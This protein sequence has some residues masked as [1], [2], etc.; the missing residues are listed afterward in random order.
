MGLAHGVGTWFLFMVF[1]YQVLDVDSHAE[2]RAGVDKDLA[3]EHQHRAVY[4]ASR[5]Q[6]Q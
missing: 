3:K 2:D 6:G 5:R 1:V 4:L